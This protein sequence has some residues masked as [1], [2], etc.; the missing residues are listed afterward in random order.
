LSLRDIHLRPTGDRRV[1]RAR[2]V[3]GITANDGWVLGQSQSEGS[4]GDGIAIGLG[5]LVSSAV[6][7]YPQDT[8]VEVSW[9]YAV[10]LP[11]GPG[12]TVPVQVVMLVFAAVG[13][14]PDGHPDPMLCRTGRHDVSV[15]VRM[16]P[17]LFH[18]PE[19][20][21]VEVSIRCG[22]EI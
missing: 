16:G 20:G 3:E 2:T 4:G 12:V 22:S 7:P 15:A 14:A 13:D 5:E 18:G 9:S 11:L 6:L 17:A 10:E 19:Q 1:L 8:A 21:K